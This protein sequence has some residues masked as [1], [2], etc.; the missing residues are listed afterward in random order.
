MRRRAGLLAAAGRRAAS[1]GGT[2]AAGVRAGP[3]APVGYRGDNSALTVL[4][5]GGSRPAEW[6]SVWDTGTLVVQGANVTIDH[7]RINASVVFTNSNPTMTNCVVTA[8]P[9]DIFGVALSGGGRGYLNISDTTVIG[10]PDIPN[11]EPQTNAIVSDSGL[12]AVRCDVSGTGDGIHHVAQSGTPSKI[13]QCYVHDLAF[14]DEEQHCDGLQGFNPYETT[15]PGAYII[16]HS[17]VAAVFSTGGTP[18]SGGSTAGPPTANTEPLVTGTYNNNFIG[19]GLYHLRIN[20]RHQNTVVTNNNLGTVAV[21]EFG[22]YVVEQPASIA[23][24]TNNR[25]GSDGSGTLIPQP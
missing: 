3:S 17:Y 22:L 9:G 24:W 8:N 1:G 11:S 13:S 21:G 6:N 10:Q 12:I 19:G 20:F 4:N 18:M 16:E 25:Q 7:Y 15:N 2:L 5:V 14:I 23:T